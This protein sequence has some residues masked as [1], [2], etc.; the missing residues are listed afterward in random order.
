MEK[1]HCVGQARCGTEVHG[2]PWLVRSG[3]PPITTKG[4]CS[5]VEGHSGK[6]AGFKSHLHHIEVT[7]E[8]KLLRV[9][10]FSS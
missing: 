8:I 7:L 10:N 6:T 3:H 4:Q 2:P 1:G 5:I 9:L